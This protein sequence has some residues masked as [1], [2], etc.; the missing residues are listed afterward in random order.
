MDSSLPRT[1]G[2]TRLAS[3]RKRTSGVLPMTSRTVSWKRTAAR[4]G[5]TEPVTACTSM[6]EGPAPRRRAAEPD[7]SLVHHLGEL[8]RVVPGRIVGRIVA[9]DAQALGRRRRLGG[10]HVV[11]GAHAMAH[12]ALHVAEPGRRGHAG[13][14]AGLVPARHVALHALRSRILRLL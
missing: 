3:E 4:R 2:G 10:E 7:E 1:S 11:L 5:G 13:E 9:R 6:G 12:L 14:A 8:G